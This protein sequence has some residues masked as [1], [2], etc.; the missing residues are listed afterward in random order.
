M[1]RTRNKSFLQN[2]LAPAAISVVALTSSLPSYAADE[3]KG[4]EEL[5]NTVINL[6][7]GLVQKGVLTKEQAEAMVA[8]AQEKATATAK[9]QADLATAE[10]DA[11]RVTY[12][13]EIVREKMRAEM[14]AEIKDDVAKDVIAAAKKEGWGVPGALPEW[15]KNVRLYGDVRARAQ[16]DWYASDNLNNVYL[17]INAVNDSR[18]ITS[19]GTSGLLNVAQDRKRFVGRVRTGVNAQ[20]G[21]AFS[22]DF[23]LA[24]GNDLSPVSTNQTLGNYGSRWT[25]NVDR[26]AVIWNPIND[27]RR[28]EFDFRF[29]RFA[30]PFV[31]INELIWDNDLTFEGIAATYAFDLFGNKDNKMERGVF[32]TVGAF[33]LQ[34]VELSA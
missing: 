22:L 31:S 33:P 34:E 18:G 20:L 3:T 23:R 25:L 14:R 19:A 6:L 2:Y 17:D 27:E 9:A 16:A 12:V 11:V 26:A 21:N 24:S 30:N 7:E 15:A 10:K 8:A 5:R 13:P 1:T 32:L 28:Q 29:G 4:L